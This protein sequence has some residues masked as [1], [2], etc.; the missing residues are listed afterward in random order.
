MTGM[1]PT[2]F[3]HPDSHH[4]FDEF[5]RVARAGGEFRCRAQD[6]RRDGTVF[7]VEVTGR[8]FTYQGRPALLGVVR[9]MSAQT[10]SEQHY[11]GIFEATTDSLLI[12]APGDLHVVEA[13]AAACTMFGYSREELLGK[14]PSELMQPGSWDPDFINAA[15]D[16]RPRRTRALGIRRDGTTFDMESTGVPFLLKGEPHLLC[17]QR[18]TTDQVR[19]EQLLERRVEARTRELATLLEISRNVAMTL[20]LGSLLDLI[21]EE[22]RRVVDYHR[23]TFS[24]AEGDELVVA[25]AA[26]SRALPD[27]LVKHDMG[28]RFPMQGEPLWK[29]IKAGQSILIRDVREKSEMARSWRSIMASSGDTGLRRVRS[30]IGVPLLVKGRV[31]GL[32]AMS[33]IEPGGFDERHAE[34]AATFAAQAAVAIE[35]ARLYDQAQRAAV[36][37]ERQRLARELHDSVSQALYGIALGASTARTLLKR[38]PSAAAEPLDYILTLAEGALAEMRALIFELRPEFLEKEGLVAAIGK[39]VE[40]TAVR[41]GLHI[42]WA[43]PEEPSAPL[44]VKEAAFRIVQEALH[45]VVK[46]ARASSVKV[47]I[48]AT[49]GGLALLVS[50][51]GV[52]FDDEETSAGHLGLKSMRERAGF[53]RG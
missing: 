23:A 21:L 36:L 17:V 52:G 11:R 37:D 18:D 9:D 41:H 44:A 50:D 27:R 43:P 47:R 12:H 1:H 51:D 28:R 3:I 15:R 31:V 26:G 34:L 30:W 4:L 32:L 22:T 16:G 5:V 53:E 49:Q 10:Y 29:A 46:H 38:D 35:N 25:A 20:D 19:S 45:N 2:Q 33:R 42:D 39:R 7:D 24:L 8:S 14:L 48:Q 40:A 6:V 13:N